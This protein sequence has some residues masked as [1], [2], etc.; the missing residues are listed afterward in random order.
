MMPRNSARTSGRADG[1]PKPEELTVR[2]KHHWW[3]INRQSTFGVVIGMLGAFA[4][5]FIPI[6]N[7][8]STALITAATF[9]IGFDPQSPAFR[10]YFAYDRVNRTVVAMNRWGRWRSYPRVDSA[11]FEL[12]H[13][14]GELQEVQPDGK[15]TSLHINR[16]RAN[17]EDW[18]AF[19]AYLRRDQAL[20]GQ[21]PMRTSHGTAA[22]GPEPGADVGA[23]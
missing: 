19:L 7:L 8:L 14:T 20:Y 12:V 22:I 11:W 6:S 16:K 18:E 4:G 17:P 5:T 13:R 2:S 3:R 1:E 9:I 15:R 23:S 21:R 10:R